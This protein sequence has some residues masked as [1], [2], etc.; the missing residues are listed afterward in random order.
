[1]QKETGKLSLVSQPAATA[2]W[3]PGIRPAPVGSEGNDPITAIPFDPANI[4]YYHPPPNPSPAMPAYPTQV[5]HNPNNPTYD[6]NPYV[7][8][9]PQSYP[10][11]P[12]Q[13]TY[14]PYTDPAAMTYQT[15]YTPYYNYAPEAVVGPAPMAT[16]TAAAAIPTH[17]E[18]TVAYPYMQQDY[19]ML[20][21]NNYYQYQ[22]GSDHTPQQYSASGF[23]QG[24]E[25]LQYGNSTLY[26]QTQQLTP[27]T[28][29]SSQ[30]YN[31][32]MQPLMQQQSMQSWS[33]Y[34]YSNGQPGNN[35]ATYQQADGYSRTSLTSSSSANGIMASPSVASSNI[36][37]LAGM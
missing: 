10:A 34:S 26:T 11:N 12:P 20:Y 9:L 29:T 30:V 16:S 6:Y 13:S 18:S 21:G 28:P 3:V 19:N 36:D 5:Y 35:V 15:N 22:P 17:N 7:E 23:Q 8:A 32:G 31:D 2:A 33:A 1:M 27:F 37:L 24:A 14:A 4:P 25:Y